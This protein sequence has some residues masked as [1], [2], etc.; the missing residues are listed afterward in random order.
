MNLIEL[1]NAISD[2]S[3]QE[4]NNILNFLL[5]NDKIIKF[6]HKYQWKG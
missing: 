1:C 6:E 2:V 3:E 5:D 4:I